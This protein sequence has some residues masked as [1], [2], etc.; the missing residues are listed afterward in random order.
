MILKF[1]ASGVN[2]TVL[3]HVRQS[4]RPMV[5]RRDLLPLTHQRPERPVSN[6]P[7]GVAAPVLRGVLWD[8]EGPVKRVPTSSTFDRLTS[9]VAS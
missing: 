2:G 1:S 3:T 9:E 6:R 8:R 4:A 7:Q 5:A